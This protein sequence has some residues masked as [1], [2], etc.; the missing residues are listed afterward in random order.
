MSVRLT[1]RDGYRN[2]PTLENAKDGVIQVSEI[3]EKSDYYPF[4]LKQKGNDLPDYSAINKYKYGY[5][6][7]ELNDELGLDLYDFGARNYDPA[8]GRWLNVD[9]SG[10]KFKKYGHLTNY[11][12][13]N[14]IF[15]VDPDGMQAKKFE[16][17]KPVVDVNDLM[18][19]NGYYETKIGEFAGAANF[20]GFYGNSR[21]GK[22]DIIGTDGNAI[23]YTLD[24]QKSITWSE[25]TP[26][27]FQGIANELILNS[28][29]GKSE[30]D[31][32]L[33]NSMYKYIVEIKEDLIE[34]KDGTLHGVFIPNLDYVKPDD[35]TVYNANIILYKG[36]L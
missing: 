23:S 34:D 8:L 10:R 12:Y 27:E 17:L 14:P 22:D 6:G 7:K 18:V 36:G 30:L 13:N 21:Y 5:G 32:I 25:N 9:P 20:R 31:E 24:E 16:E 35:D 3:I 26:K 29:S 33:Y 11:A 15:F 28:P 19:S 4:G 1:Y 2:H